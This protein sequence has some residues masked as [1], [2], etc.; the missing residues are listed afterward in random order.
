MTKFVLEA[1]YHGTKKVASIFRESNFTS[2]I[3]QPE[4]QSEC[5]HRPRIG[6]KATVHFHGACRADV[7]THHTRKAL[8]CGA[9][10]C[11]CLP[12]VRD[13]ISVGVHHLQSAIIKPAT[14]H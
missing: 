6:G 9:I 13:R 11:E 8:G 7:G 14:R 5:N 3:N 4:K 1:Y 12:F 2:A 10:D